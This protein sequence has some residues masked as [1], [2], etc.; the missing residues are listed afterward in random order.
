MFK[1]M[2]DSVSNIHRRWS[3][4]RL[5]PSSYK[6]SYIIAVLSIS[7]IV[8]ITQTH[9]NKTDKIHLLYSILL[10]QASLTAACFLDFVSLHGTPLNKISKIFHISAF[11][12]LLWL[13]TVIL[14]VTSGLL[15]AKNGSSFNNYV[16]E[17]MLLACGLRIGIFIS[18][19]GA[20]H[21]RSIA[22]S[23]LQPIILLFVFERTWS[24]YHDLLI[25]PIGLEFGLALI[26]VSIS[27][28]VVADRAGRPGIKSTFAILQAFLAAWT[29][30]KIENMEKIAESK[31]HMEVIKTYIIK[32][33]VINSKEISIILPEVHPGPFNPVGGS[34][35]PY[36]LYTLFSKNALVMHGI[37]DHS[38]NIPSKREV[39]RYAATLS[40]VVVLE[41]GNSCTIPVQIKIGEST[42]TGI[43]FGNSA[44]VILSMAPKGMEDVPNSI[45]TDIEKYSLR[46]GFNYIL[47]ID[48]HNAMGGHLTGSDTYNLLSATKKCLETLKGAKQNEF[49]IGFA[50]SDGIYSK[51]GSIEDLGQAGLASIAIQIRENRYA[52]GWADSNN[53]QNGLRERIIFTLSNYGMEMI[54]ICT[55]DTHTT[56]GKRTRQGYFAL[57]DRS[58]LDQV[59][60]MYLQVA[61]KSVKKMEL[62]SFELLLSES[63]IKVMGKNQFDDY[64]CALDKSMNIT[65][66]FVGITLVIFISMFIVS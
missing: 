22:V 11:T 16:I 8:F 15:L 20:G 26:V 34:N 14:G 43:A 61:K 9:N 54:E 33:K 58:D 40:E 4:T 48:S 42:V 47:I 21:G 10:G 62:A 30:N 45:R 38:L 64:S 28:T 55:S 46:L 41:K 57:G 6:I 56:S 5:N 18:V 31:A 1:S 60:H 25:H 13:F 24:Y 36:V 49:K 39:E 23:F 50:N 59:T 32:F 2:P 37:S 7:S 27:W 63:N 65:K 35:L 19:F 53:M 44:M 52:L 3:F 51:E 29:E 12:S 17:G 66:I